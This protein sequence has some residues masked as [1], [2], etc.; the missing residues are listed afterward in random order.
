MGKQKLILLL[1]N[2]LGGA[3]VIGSY[4]LGLR[5]GSSAAVLW[6]GVPESIRPVYTVSMVICALG[7]FAFLYFLLV[8]TV[9]GNVVIS[10]RFGYGLFHWIFL[11]ILVPSAFW[12]PLTNLY[13]GDPHT[14]T[15]IAVRVVLVIVGLASIALAW[16]LLTLQPNNRGPAYWSAVA[17]SCYFA[18]HTAIL[19]AIIWAALFR[20]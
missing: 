19:D 18:F 16:A 5:G 1:I 14:G 3:A 6:G 17:G 15:W 8:K 20:T 2:V 4:V 13:V 12:M 11:L 9:P 10:G 7:Y